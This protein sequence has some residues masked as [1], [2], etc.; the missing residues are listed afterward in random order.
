MQGLHADL[1]FIIGA[2]HRILCNT[3]AGATSSCILQL[4]TVLA[5]LLLLQYPVSFLRRVVSRFCARGVSE[6]RQATWI[7]C[8][9]VLL[10][11]L[12]AVAM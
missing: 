8:A 1:S 2:F 9:P 4:L 5:E 7:V 6:A 11:M 3:S 12:R 10:S